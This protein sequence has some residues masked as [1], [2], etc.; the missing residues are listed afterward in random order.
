VG[1]D[2]G[3][4][5]RYAVN[6]ANGVFSVGANPD[7][8]YA[9]GGPPGTH[10]VGTPVLTSGGIVIVSDSYGRVHGVS[11]ANGASLWLTTI[12]GTITAPLDGKNIYVGCADPPR[13]YVLG[14][15]GGTVVDYKTVA[16]SVT[17][18]PAYANF[19]GDDLL[20]LPGLVYATT[21]DGHLYKWIDNNGFLTLDWTFVPPLG[22]TCSSWPMLAG[23]ERIYCGMYDALT[24]N[25][26]IYA[27][28]QNGA[29]QQ[30][31]SR[32]D[33]PV[34]RVA[35]AGPPPP[36]QV[37]IGKI[38]ANPCNDMGGSPNV[39]FPSRH[40]GSGNGRAMIT[41]TLDL[42][43]GS[44]AG[45][46]CLLA[47]DLYSV[48]D[49]SSTA[50]YGVKGGTN[51]LYFVSDNGYYYVVDALSGAMA[52]TFP[53]SLNLTIAR[54]DPSLDYDGAIVFVSND[55]VVRAYWGQSTQ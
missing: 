13:V 19:G 33:N 4:L 30:A 3:Y 24:N 23:I 43:P 5:C 51:H 28:Y 39:Y 6:Y 52:Y 12:G 41:R 22:Q 20:A 48:P 29:D 55:G 47:G 11:E 15:S 26:S 53:K 42:S 31:V 49:V 36:H 9:V 21:S 34:T 16:T 18:I 17:S 50:V 54:Q 25:G 14:R 46:G 27:F 1:T 45:A 10:T 38:L 7:W 40:E 8:A 2:D 37:D 44:P 32:W 35:A